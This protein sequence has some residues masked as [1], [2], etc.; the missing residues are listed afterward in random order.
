M[1]AL[2][3]FNRGVATASEYKST[4]LLCNLGSFLSTMNLTLFVKLILKKIIIKILEYDI[5]FLKILFYDQPC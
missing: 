5:D 1:P 4:H 2:F 3:Q